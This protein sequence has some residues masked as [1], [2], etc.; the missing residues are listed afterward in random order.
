MNERPIEETER[1]TK[2]ITIRKNPD[3]F[4]YGKSGNRVKVY[5]DGENPKS[6]IKKIK[7]VQNALETMGMSAP[8]SSVG[9]KKFVKYG[10]DTMSEE[11]K[12]ETKKKLDEK[13]RKELEDFGS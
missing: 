4:E 10:D 12:E 2:V 8:D 5:F 1:T 13:S 6:L 7:N 9:N 11:E 3:S